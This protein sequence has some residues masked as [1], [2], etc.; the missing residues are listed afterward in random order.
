MPLIDARRAGALR[1][2]PGCDPDARSPLMLPGA[3]ERASH[4]RDVRVVAPDRGHDIASILW[5]S[6][7]RIE[8]MPGAFCVD[9]DPGMARLLEDNAARWGEVAAD[10]TGGE[11]CD[12]QRRR[13]EVRKVLAHAPPQ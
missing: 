6:V 9:L 3:T 7:R 2:L 10:V 13:H 4:R 8:A 11:S 1:V 12:A 5:C